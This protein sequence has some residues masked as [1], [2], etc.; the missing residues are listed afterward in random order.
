M[1]VVF[2]G[3]NP[4]TV[5]IVQFIED[6][7]GNMVNSKPIIDIGNFVNQPRYEEVGSYS[8]ADAYQSRYPE[9]VYLDDLGFVRSRLEGAISSEQEKPSQLREIGPPIAILRI[10][11]TGAFWESRG[12]C[13]KIRTSK[14]KP[15]SGKK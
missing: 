3:A 12:L 10:N 6:A 7:Q 2:A 1:S 9:V 8:G 4:F 11:Q 13:E 14:S 5:V 15:T